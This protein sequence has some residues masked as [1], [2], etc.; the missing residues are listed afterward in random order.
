MKTIVVMGRG[1]TGK[2]S[3][4][5]LIADYFIK[6]GQ[7]PLLLVD[8]DPDQS[9]GEMIGVD[10][11][12]E[13]KKSI[14]ELIEDTFIE[15]GGTTIGIPPSRR[16]EN[17]IWQDGMY[18][19]RHFDFI[20]IGTKWVEGCY[21]MPDAAL[22]DALGRLVRQYRYVL[23]DAPGG[24]EHLNRRVTT[25]VNDIIDVLGPS[26]KSF[27]HLERAKRIADECGIKYERF[28]SVGGY[29]FPEELT[30]RAMSVSGVLHLG[31][32]SYDGEVLRRT[33][34]GESIPGIP[35]GNPGPESVERILK[36]AGY[37]G[38]NSS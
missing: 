32:I 11:Q 30:E 15:K 16:I 3:F 21:C 37:A 13:G 25:Q 5:S 18:E 1:G 29:Q 10:L 26:A 6:T 2:T 31:K 27:A 7:T 33:I 19:G 4:V 14:S 8:L 34:T 9:L 17:R 35:P 38:D 23:I 22:R 24:L 20:A 28:I 12:D 36:K